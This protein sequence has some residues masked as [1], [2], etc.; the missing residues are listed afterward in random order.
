[1]KIQLRHLSKHKNL[2]TMLR[3]QIDLS[4]ND[5]AIRLLTVKLRAHL[6]GKVIVQLYRERYHTLTARVKTEVENFYLP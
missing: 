6:I 5:C 4:F 1:M 3:L 2:V